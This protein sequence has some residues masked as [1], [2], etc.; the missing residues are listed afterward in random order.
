MTCPRLQSSISSLPTLPALETVCEQANSWAPQDPELQPS[1][2]TASSGAV[3]VLL[4]P[5]LLPIC[6]SPPVVPEPARPKEWVHK[7]NVCISPAFCG[8][9]FLF[10][11]HGNGL[12]TFSLPRLFAV[13]I[14]IILVTKAYIRVLVGN[15]RHTRG[16]T[17]G[18]SLEG[19]FMKS[20]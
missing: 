2:L 16:S 10:S 9:W 11:G 8:I 15:K 3:A 17:G 7:E 14:T 18:S 13:I 1:G 20:W 19:L 12:V 4:G 6:F 5:G